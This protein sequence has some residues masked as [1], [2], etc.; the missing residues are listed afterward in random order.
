MVL[1]YKNSEGWMGSVHKLERKSCMQ[2]SVLR[3][4]LP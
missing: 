1:A 3:L 4:R 2:A